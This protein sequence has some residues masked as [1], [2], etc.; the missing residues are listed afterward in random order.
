MCNAYGSIQNWSNWVIVKNRREKRSKSKQQQEKSAI[1]T[2]MRNT[3]QTADAI[4]YSQRAA[5]IQAG[6]T[7]LGQCFC[8]LVML[9]SCKSGTFL[10]WNCWGVVMLVHSP[11]RKLLLARANHTNRSTPSGHPAKIDTYDLR[12]R[13]VASVVDYEWAL[14]LFIRSK[15]G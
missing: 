13:Q 15:H 7:Q 6:P 4:W 2:D 14:W 8:S 9:L 1:R 12:G 3:L 5:H 11:R 10:V